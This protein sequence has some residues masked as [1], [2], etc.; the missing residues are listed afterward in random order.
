MKVVVMDDAGLLGVETALWVR[1]H[2]HEVEMLSAPHGPD[3]LTGEE[4]TEALHGC[5]V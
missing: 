4:I 2:G 3:S 5:S 1:D